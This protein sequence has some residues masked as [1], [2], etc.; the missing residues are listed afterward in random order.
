[1]IRWPAL[2]PYTVVFT[3]RRGGVSEGPYASLNLGLLT[4]D[5][6]ARVAENRRLA[7]GRAGID[8]ER[9]AMNRQVH[10]A[11]VNRARPGERGRDGDG[12]WTDGRDVPLLAL[13]ADCLPVV[14]IRRNGNGPSLAVLHVGRLGLLEGIVAAGVAALEGGSVDAVVGP[15][16]GVCCYEVGE[17]VAGPFRARFGANVLQDGRLDLRAAAELALEKAGVSRIDHVADCTACDETRF[18]SHRRDGPRTGRQGV[19]AC[20]G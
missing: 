9:L 18:F 12:L 5:E 20:I 6:P 4:Q 15:G 16:I 13:A 1:M 14:L 10:G 7:C 3:T 2:E 19:L 8:P 17:E 11:V